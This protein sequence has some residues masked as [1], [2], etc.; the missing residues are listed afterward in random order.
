MIIEEGN[1]RI[2]ATFSEDRTHRYSLRR[3][4]WDDDSKPTATA[5]I[6]MSHASGADIVKG[7]L[8]T[9]VL[10]QNSLAALGYRAVTCCN[11]LSYIT[12][13]GKLDLS[14]DISDFTNEDNTQVTL[15]AIRETD[16]CIIAIGSLSTTHKKVAVH[17]HRLFDLLRAEGFQ[18]KIYTISAPDGS[19]QLHPSSGKLRAAG[20]W[21]LV[22]YELPTPPPAEKEMAGVSID[23]DNTTKSGKSKKSNK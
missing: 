16:I 21:K 3:E 11:L 14:G 12:S 2:T 13:D 18:D 8:T 10:I 20:S 17:Q 19:E 23:T 1:I 5:T 6:I 4:W 7:D 22:P 15:Q 9:S